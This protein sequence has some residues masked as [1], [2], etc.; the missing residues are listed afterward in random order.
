MT[1]R[2]ALPSTRKESG[3]VQKR[4]LSPEG[5]SFQEAVLSPLQGALK[6][7]TVFDYVLQDS[8]TQNSSDGHQVVLTTGDKVGFH[9]VEMA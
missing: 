5:R 9:R 8:G 3:L 2:S 4:G 6:M 1:R 7:G